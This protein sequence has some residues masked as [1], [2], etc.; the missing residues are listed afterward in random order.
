MSLSPPEAAPLSPPPSPP[1]GAPPRRAALRDLAHALADRANPVLVRFVRQQLKSRAFLLLYVVT[2]LAATLFSLSLGSRS[3]QMAE[4]DAALNL[5]GALAAVWS[6]AVW[7]FEPISVYR[8]VTA[9]RE[10]A[11]WDLVELTGMRPR[12]VLSGLLQAAAVHSALYA[13]A[14]APFVLMAYLLRGVD[15][16]T[17]ITLLTYVPLVG[18]AGVATGIFAGCV[19]TT[20]AVR[21]LT[22]VVLTLG[23]VGVWLTH[24]NLWGDFDDFA[25]G[26]QRLLHGPL[27]LAITGMYFNFFAAWILLMLSLSAGLITSRVANRSTLPRLVWMLLSLNAIGWLVALGLIGGELEATLT[28]AA[29]CG[30]VATPLLGLFSVTED[31]T[32]TPRQA[33]D[34]RSARPWVRPFMVVLGP[35]AARG[36]LAFLAMAAVTIG[37]A[38]WALANHRT[39]EPALFALS[40]LAL[41][42]LYLLVG[43]TLAR[44]PFARLCP[45]ATH[46]RALILVMLV[47]G[48]M[49]V[50]VLGA[51]SAFQVQE[52]ALIGPFPGAWVIAEG[53]VAPT[54]V[55][56]VLAAGVLALTIL[57]AQALGRLR[58]TT[59]QVFARGDDRNPRAG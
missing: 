41:T 36:R 39:D 20:R 16:A 49:L 53:V 3:A 18:L 54:S 56:A 5:L 46:R 19:G 25:R 29:V 13:A 23:C 12:V 17:L 26:V 22:S 45:T 32:L 14:I 48:A 27:P 9:E 4:G 51:M 43:D 58:V 28:V 38:L 55:M 7:V 40:F 8:A 1:E 34:L 42:S 50:A 10:D 33:R 15:L 52:V 37:L 6:L 31:W 11:T 59:Q 44:G 57:T 30:A 35:G 2:L 24:M 21:S 47:L